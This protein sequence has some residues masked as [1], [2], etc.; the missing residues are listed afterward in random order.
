MHH[1]FYTIIIKDM[2]WIPQGVFGQGSKVGETGSAK[3]LANTLS[4]SK[5]V[6]SDYLK[7]LLGAEWLRQESKR[8]IEGLIGFLE[9][10]RPKPRQSEVTENLLGVKD[11][12]LLIDGYPIPIDLRK[13][14][15]DNMINNPKDSLYPWFI[16]SLLNIFAELNNKQFDWWDLTEDNL[17]SGELSEEQIIEQLESWDNYA[18]LSLAGQILDTIWVIPFGRTNTW[19]IIQVSFEPDIVQF[20]CHD[21]KRDGNE[22]SDI[23]RS[24]RI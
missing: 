22:M 21:Q 23:I 6:T 7:K 16:I 3:E 12:L 20:C 8:Y 13:D 18:V 11:W 4:D 10:S 14:T 19:K 9:N 2:L 15:I 17:I 5:Y 24:I 1:I